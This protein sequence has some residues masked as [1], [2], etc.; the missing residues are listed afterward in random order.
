MRFGVQ[1]RPQAPPDGA[2]IVERWE[3]VIEASVIAEEAG[4]DG[5]FVPEHHMMAD[6][7]PPSPWAGLG[8]IAARTKRVH[9]G[10]G[11]YL[12]PLR[13]PLQAAEDAAMLDIVSNGRLRWGVG[14]GNYAP[15]YE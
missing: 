6:G 3:E 10:T 4:F 7:Y 12:L 8:A 9:V 13:H 15:E 11:V 1:F 14:L 5:V 2:R